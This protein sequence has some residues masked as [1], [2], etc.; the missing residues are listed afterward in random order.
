[1]ELVPTPCRRPSFRRLQGTRVRARE[2][3]DAPAP[4]RLPWGKIPPPKQS[5]FRLCSDPVHFSSLF[6]KK[7]LTYIVRYIIIELWKG[8]KTLSRKRKSGSK[9]QPD[10]Y[11]TLATA[12]I[13]LVISLI[14]LLEKLTK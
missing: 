11:I 10:S 3:I 7:S 4:A 2:W 14:L 12:I 8:G 13:N 5:P 1:M 9:G 6:S